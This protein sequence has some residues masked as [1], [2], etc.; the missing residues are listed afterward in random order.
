MG[1]KFDKVMA[2]S[3]SLYCQSPGSCEDHHFQCAVPDSHKESQRERWQEVSSAPTIFAS[4]WSFC[5]FFRS[6]NVF[7]TMTQQGHGLS[8]T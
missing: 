4:V 6:G 5:F 3:A 7:E 2:F 1:P 8:S